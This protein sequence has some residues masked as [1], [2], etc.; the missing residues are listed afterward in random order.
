MTPR[1]PF[2]SLR[3]GLDYDTSSGVESS[4]DESD[5]NDL[6][7]LRSCQVT[8]GTWAGRTGRNLGGE[9]NA[10]GLRQLGVAE[11]GVAAKVDR[12]FVDVEQQAVVKCSESFLV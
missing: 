5:V 3:R 1:G 2:Y 7:Y 10:S 6:G 9:F 12:W 8:P 4:L 11:G